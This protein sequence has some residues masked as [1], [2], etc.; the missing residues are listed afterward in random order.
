MSQPSCVNPPCQNAVLNMIGLIINIIPVLFML[1]IAKLDLP[2][3][4]I[5]G[6]IILPLLWAY[7]LSCLIIS[8]YLKIKEKKENQIIKTKNKE[9]K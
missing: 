5:L 3:L 6:Y 4:A 1:L 7:F 8:I 2:V 9:N